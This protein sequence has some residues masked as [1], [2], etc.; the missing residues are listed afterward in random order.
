MKYTR[1]YSAED[2][3]DHIP[4]LLF[5]F[6]DVTSEEER[7]LDGYDT[8]KLAVTDERG[9]EPAEACGRFLFASNDG[10]QHPLPL[11]LT[12]LRRATVNNIIKQLVAEQ[13]LFVF[14][15]MDNRYVE[16]CF[17][18]QGMLLAKSPVTMLQ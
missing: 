12:S 16:Y 2:S 15:R 9:D 14:I 18:A 6:T 10:T 11:R 7:I 8:Y 17:N 5:Y 1:V 13:K 3:A 4:F